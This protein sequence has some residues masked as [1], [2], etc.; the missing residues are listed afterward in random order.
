MF[1]HLAKGGYATVTVDASHTC[2]CKTQRLYNDLGHLDGSSIIECVLLQAIQ[3]LPCTPIVD[4]IL[5]KA[6]EVDIHMRYHGITLTDWCAQND[7]TTRRKHAYSMILSITRACLHL[8]HMGIQH[9]DLKPTNILIHADLSV[10]II[11]FNSC[12]TRS[13]RKRDASWGYAL[14]TWCYAAPEVVEHCVAADTTMV[15]SIALLLS[16]IYHKHPLHSLWKGCH[17]KIEDRGEWYRFLGRLRDADAQGLPLG[18]HVLQQ[19]PLEFHKVLQQCTRWRSSDRWSLEKLYRTLV[20]MRHPAD[21]IPNI[22]RYKHIMYPRPHQEQRQQDVLQMYQWCLNTNNLYVLSRALGL[23]DR[24]TGDLTLTTCAAM[25]ALSKMLVAEQLDAEDVATQR[26]YDQFATTQPDINEEI[27]AICTSFSWCAYDI[28]ADVLVWDMYT[29]LP[30]PSRRSIHN[31]VYAVQS[32]RTEPYT[33]H[34]IALQV[35]KEMR[36]LET[37]ENDS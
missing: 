1:S 15:W 9:T 36:G 5:V 11:D 35:F 20:A 7:L 2:I 31:H 21:A 37:K 3:T 26:M 29:E 25:L 16:Y 19:I 6:K 8:A 24:Y 33:M 14:G 17:V 13:T 28:P 22:P 23:Y 10:T 27:V 18:H 32:N 12:A 30:R 34:E 4:K